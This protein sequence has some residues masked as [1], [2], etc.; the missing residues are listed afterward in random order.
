[1]TSSV[2]LHREEPKVNDQQAEVASSNDAQHEEDVGPSLHFRLP[3]HT[4]WGQQVRI[5]GGGPTL[6]SGDPLSGYMMS[7][8][9]SGLLHRDPPPGRQSSTIGGYAPRFSFVYLL[10]T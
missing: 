7:C 10:V 2:N 3:Y 9:Y 8:R 6:G 4:T 1:M 5:V